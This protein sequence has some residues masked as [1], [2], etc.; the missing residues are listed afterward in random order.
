MR[1][2]ELTFSVGFEVLTAKAMKSTI[3]LYVLSRSL[4]EVYQLFGDAATISRVNP[5]KQL[6][7]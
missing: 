3:F 7:E 6:L 5:S 2:I 4:V 1:M